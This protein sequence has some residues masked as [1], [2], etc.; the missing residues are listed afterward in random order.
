[1]ARLPS[2]DS[3]YV[4]AVAA[5]HLNFTTAAAEL[6]RTQSAVSHRMK[7][8]EGEIG[9]RLFNRDAR[10]LKL[11]S[12]GETLAHQIDQSIAD[13]TRTIAGLDRASA[14][15]KLRVTMLP[16]VASRWLMPRLARFCERHPDIQVQVLA[17][18]RIL[19]LRTEGIDLAIRFGHGHYRG[20]G[21]T[22]L[23]P[24]RALPVCS[25][26]LLTGGRRVP[27]IDALLAL[28]L[29]H[30]SSAEGDRSLS[31]WH[32]WL[33]QLGRSDVPCHGG[34]RFSHA[35]LSIEAAQ[36]GL[37]VAL[38]RFSLVADLLAKG[39]LVCPLPLT[40]ATAFSYYL[41]ALPEVAAQPEIAVFIKWLVAEADETLA[42]ARGIE[43]EE[44]RFRVATN[45][46]PAHAF[47]ARGA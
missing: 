27:T 38:A 14:A 11:T 32:S 21:T 17:D 2:L 5:R 24:D 28:P 9:V 6:H 44:A 8:L 45:L 42:L 19:D 25:P 18:A 16:S 10:G 30:D 12:A 46:P 33:E 26:Q 20:Y 40:S 22:V 13:L 39:V 36:L 15:R 3:L 31:D 35:G 29:L 1:M 23:M 41:V 43:T 7:A 4:F 47:H 37:G 34:Q